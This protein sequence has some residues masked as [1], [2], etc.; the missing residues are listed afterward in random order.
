MKPNILILLMIFPLVFSS[1]RKDFEF[2]EFDYTTYNRVIGPQGGSIDFYGNYKNDRQNNVIVNF[3]VPS[4][5]L[6]SMMVFNMY[7]Y[8]NYELATLMEDGFAKFGTKLLY[9]V[10][11][12]ESEGY[13]ER[14]QFERNYH[15]SVK[16]KKPITVTYY[17]MA[18]YSD[19]SFKNW[20]EVV[21]FQNYY[22]TTNKAYKVYRIKIPK[23]DEW[24]TY[25]NIFVNWSGQGYPNG[26]DPT[27]I[28]YIVNGR[29]SL[30][31]AWGTGEISMIN[32]E[33][34]VRGEDYEL[35]PIND[36]VTFKIYDSDYIYVVARD[37]YLKIL[38]A[39]INSYVT[40]NFTGLQVQRA[41]FDDNQYKVYFTNRTVAVFNQWQGFDYLLNENL[42]FSNLPNE[43]QNDVGKFAEEVIKVSLKQ[44][45]GGYLIYEVTLKSGIYI[46]YDG[47][48]FQRLTFYQYGYNPSN[49]NPLILQHIKN[50]Y[51]GQVITNVVYTS[52]YGW[53]EYVVYLSSNARV[54]FD[55]DANWYKTI[56]YKIG[57]D[58]VPT[59]VMNYF[60]DNFPNT[61]FQEINITFWPEGIPIFD[62]YMVGNKWFRISS[63]GKTYELLEFVFKNLPASEIPVIIKDRI[64]SSFPDKTVFSVWHLYSDRSERFEVYFTD[65]TRANISA[66][67]VLLN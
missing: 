4:G 5:A 43:I 23:I 63:D 29:W 49:L 42:F 58:K 47:I 66:S 67:G 31:S 41:S 10:P 55:S 15:L 56:Y 38:P 51:P 25:H 53:T 61:D 8:E 59:V 20:Q 16:F 50:N 60:K 19:F 9:F 36:K 37:V 6:D 1:C 44:Y 21:L 45:E 39:S 65:Y 17:P 32:W 30:A 12:Y 62:F 40:G 13:H 54:Y 52:N 27:D 28:T 3:N 33:E 11:F 22:K 64:E 18:N 14:G 48:S 46:T 7:Q 2:T 24:G 35:D 26:Y 34:L 57:S